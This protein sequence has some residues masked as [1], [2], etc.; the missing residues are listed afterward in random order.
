MDVSFFYCKLSGSS[1]V[2]NAFVSAVGKG[3]RKVSAIC[4]ADIGRFVGRIT[5][6]VVDQCCSLMGRAIE[7]VQSKPLSMQDFIEQLRD[8]VAKK[9]VKD[10]LGLQTREEAL[11]ALK[12]LKPF[13]ACDFS[14]Y[15]VP[16]FISA[17]DDGADMLSGDGGVFDSLRSFPDEIEAIFKRYDPSKN[18]LILTRVEIKCLYRYLRETA[19]NLTCFDFCMLDGEEGGNKGKLKC[20]DSN[21]CSKVSFSLEKSFLLFLGLSSLSVSIAAPYR[22][23]NETAVGLASTSLPLR[24]TEI[25]LASVSAEEN[26][27][28]PF[29]EVEHKPSLEELRNRKTLRCHTGDIHFS[30]YQVG[31]GIEQC[32]D[33]LDEDVGLCHG[34]GL[35][36]IACGPDAGKNMSEYSWQDEGY[37][38][39]QWRWSSYYV[40]DR[41]L[42]PNRRCIYEEMILD[43]KP[44]CFNGWDEKYRSPD[45]CP[46]N[47][48]YSVQEVA[49]LNQQEAGSDYEYR[50]WTP[51][52]DVEGV[53]C[54]EWNSIFDVKHYT[55]RSGVTME[56]VGSGKRLCNWW[57]NNPEL[58]SG[59]ITDFGYFTFYWPLRCNNSEVAYKEGKRACFLRSWFGDGKP[60]CTDGSDEW[61]INNQTCTEKALKSY[62]NVTGV[63]SHHCEAVEM[64]LVTTPMAPVYTL[65]PKPV[66]VPLKPTLKGKWVR[67]NIPAKVFGGISGFI[68]FLIGVTCIW[69]AVVIRRDDADIRPCAL[70]SQSARQTFGI[71]RYFATCCRREG[72]QSQQ[73]GDEVASSNSAHIEA[74]AALGQHDSLHES[75]SLSGL[76]LVYGMAPPTYAEAMEMM[77]MDVA[78]YRPSVRSDEGA[79]SELLMESDEHANGSMDVAEYASA[80]VAASSAGEIH[81]PDEPLPPYEQVAAVSVSTV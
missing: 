36:P 20:F 42:Y 80:F 33:G 19:P 15:E 4:S 68:V 32:P 58:C 48:F 63:C 37:R 41:T 25:P 23:E 16:D 67:W 64:P 72:E 75:V 8:E 69:R 6:N 5:S 47:T 74:A 28:H 22:Q 71:I 29:V 3:Q 77:E 54:P 18:A 53:D 61:D 70:L 66:L 79:D 52:L 81:D 76:G 31:D 44:D 11:F 30:R 27:H 39:G 65:T 10:I 21:Q 43:G 45:L 2:L 24:S 40:D 49:C 60:D 12:T 57:Q 51:R 9:K 56:G 38:D 26:T 17:E 59:R 55:G 13:D 50:Y 46:Q 35:M 7:K 73:S 78:P 1:R 34:Q 62:C 14:G